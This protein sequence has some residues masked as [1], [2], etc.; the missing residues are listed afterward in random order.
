MCFKRIRVESFGPLEKNVS[1]AAEF[2]NTP[3]G[4]TTQKLLAIKRFGP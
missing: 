2:I 4:R 1:K 3:T